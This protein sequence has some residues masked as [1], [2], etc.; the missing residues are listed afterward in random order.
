M[1]AGRKRTFDTA[2]ALDRAMRVFWHNGY[3]GTSMT[4]LTAAL[5]INKPSLYAAFGNKEQLFD[6]AVRHY[7]A[8]Y[9]APLFERLTASTDIPLIERLRSY[10]Y[11]ITDLVS[12]SG[13]PKGCLFVKSSCESGGA[14]IPDDVASSLR[15]IGHDSEQALI[16]FFG[17]EQARGQLSADAD[18]CAIAAYLLSVMY[19]L[20]V[21]ARR[22]KS[23]RE[24]EAIAD[25]SIQ[26][27]PA[28][29]I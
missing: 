23:R 27:L 7:M 4:D 28:L 11:G 2:Q 26:T 10:L 3:S 8:Q 19:G 12:A 21:M 15:E 17:A 22:G 20:A 16:D 9:G 5:G 6:A 29:G 13:S 24:L 18:P 1:T 25:T 14:A